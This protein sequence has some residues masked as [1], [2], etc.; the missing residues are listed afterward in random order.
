MI[1]H[2][3]ITLFVY[4]SHFQMHAGLESAPARPT[5]CLI[6]PATRC[7]MAAN[8]DQEPR[9]SYSEAEESEPPRSLH[10]PDDAGEVE[11]TPS[12]QELADQRIHEIL[13]ELVK[14]GGIL[15]AL[16][17]SLATRA[18]GTGKEMWQEYAPER[19][20]IFDLLVTLVVT[21]MFVAWHHASTVSDGV[22]PGV[23][24]AGPYILL[25]LLMAYQLLRHIRSLREHWQQG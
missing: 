15:A 2:R 21:T 11:S 9:S 14:D 8:R 20:F 18:W 16:F 13:R 5:R 7:D 4:V 3:S 22:L 10:E 25:V 17:I 19:R 6:L 23:L 1:S 12:L 24:N